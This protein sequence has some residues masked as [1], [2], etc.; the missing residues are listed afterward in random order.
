[1]EGLD[2][3][4]QLKELG[5]WGVAGFMIYL[6]KQERAER[7]RYRDFHESTIQSLPDLTKANQE[8]SADVKKMVADIKDHI[9]TMFTQL[10][11]NLKS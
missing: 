1:M 6:W 4:Q 5:G 7:L 10:K 8:M 11:E 9:R 2:V 3:L